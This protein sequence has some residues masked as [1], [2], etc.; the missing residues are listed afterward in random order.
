MAVPSRGDADTRGLERS[1][2]ARRSCVP[3]QELNAR[4]VCNAYLVSR[5]F[6]GMC[7]DHG[8]ARQIE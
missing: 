4:T 7:S 5:R 8:S 2:R 6:S 3:D 1:R